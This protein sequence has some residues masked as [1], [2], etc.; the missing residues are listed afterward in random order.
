[1]RGNPGGL[2]EQA[3]VV[4]DRRPFV[5]ALIQIDFDTVGKWAEEHGIAYTH[6]RSLA[7]HERVRTLAA[8]EERTL[9]PTAAMSAWRA[10]LLARDAGPTPRASGRGRRKPPGG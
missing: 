10:T 2:L 3:I 6:F 4:A 5:A 1:M 9:A 8:E 7:E